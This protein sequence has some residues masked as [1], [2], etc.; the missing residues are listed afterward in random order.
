[1]LSRNL[2][3][4]RVFLA[5]GDLRTP[6]AAAERCL[7]S[8]P[9]VT[10]ALAKM[11]REAGGDLFKRTRQ[12]FFLTPRGEAVDARLRRAMAQLDAALT[13]V[14]PR[15]T[16]TATYAQLQALITMSEAQSFMLAARNLGLAQPTVHRAISQIEQ[17]AAGSLFERTSFG[18]VAT[19]PCRDIAQAARLA[20][21]EFE[22]I[23]ADL[24]D[25][26]G[27]EVGSI[28]IG[29][30]PLPRAKL[31]PEAIARFRQLRPKQPITVIDGTYKEM[32][33]GMR[34]G[35]IDFILGALRAPLPVEDV[36]QEF[37][38]TDYLVILARSGHALEKAS[39]LTL[40]KLVEH[41]W[42]VPR[43]GT[44]TRE[45]FDTLFAGHAIPMPES[46][47]ECGSILLMR[48]LLLSSDLL[49]CISGQQAQRE[50]QAGVLVELD[51]EVD[52]PG[53]D[54]GATYRSCWVPTKA[55]AL[56]LDKL[57]EV[58]RE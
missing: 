21:A 55:Q 57:R 6:T 3:H 14:S 20:F 45:Q 31:L 39:G 47:V 30:L 44:P 50:I 25:F 29:S 49:G 2:R 16:V 36:V 15:L 38:F 1:V 34:R 13:E 35:D 41:P 27:R 43:P 28:R 54:I 53:R 17:E 40:E 23:D 56:L 5:V 42:V 10:Q 37:L 22:Q 9:A 46:I 19:R 58:A 12:G 26:D 18:L 4:F 7:V 32:L 52:W 33:A 48:E 51:A 8:Q 11:E 24:A